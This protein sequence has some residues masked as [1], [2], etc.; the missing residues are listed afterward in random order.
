[1]SRFAVSSVGCRPSRIVFFESSCEPAQ[2]LVNLRRQG[3]LFTNGPLKG[4]ND[5]DSEVAKQADKILCVRHDVRAKSLVYL[6]QKKP[7]DVDYQT[8]AMMGDNAF[9]HGCVVVTAW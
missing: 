3:A 1:M 7:L 6:R 8:A 5:R 4:Y 2:V 9:R